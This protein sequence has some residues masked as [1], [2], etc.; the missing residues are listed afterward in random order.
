M[1]WFWR[2]SDVRGFAGRA[3]IPNGRCILEHP[4]PQQAALGEP[5]RLE[6][7]FLGVDTYRWHIVSAQRRLASCVGRGAQRQGSTRAHGPRELRR[8]ARG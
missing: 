8:A 6:C 3:R 1:G 2:S 5:S 4:S 7:V